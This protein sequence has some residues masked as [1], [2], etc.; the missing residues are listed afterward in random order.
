MYNKNL[1]TFQGENTY[2]VAIRVLKHSYYRDWRS[3]GG[4]AF[5]N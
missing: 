1:F 4:A 5:V 2:A 3:I